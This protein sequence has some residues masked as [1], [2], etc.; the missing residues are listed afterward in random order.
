[1]RQSAQAWPDRIALQDLTGSI[2]V[3][4]AELWGAVESGASVLRQSGLEPRDRVLLAADAGPGWM[5]S[6][7]S[8]SHAG[9]VAVPIPPTTPEP[10]VRLVLK[11]ADVRACV[12]DRGSA[13]QATCFTP[14]DLADPTAVPLPRVASDPSTTAVLVFTSGSTSRPRAVALSH[15]ALRANLRSVQA[16]RQAQPGEALLSTLPPSH[17]YE[18]VAGQLAPLASG[19]RVVYAGVPLPN[20]V[21]DAIRTQAITRMLLVPALFEALVRDVVDGLIN[22]GVV[23]ESCRHLSPRD[24]AARAR[25]LAPDA[26]ARLRA[27]IRER[28]GT[29]LRNVTIGG[30]ATDPA[31]ADVLST[32]GIDLDVGYGL[33]EAGPVVAIGRASQCPAGSVGRPLPGVDVRIGA[34]EEVLV[35]SEAVMQGYAGDASATAAAFAGTWLRTGDRGRVDTNGFL[36]I[37]GRIKEAM[38]T[39]AG[40]T[41]YPDEIEPY[42]SSPLFAE[43]AVVPAAGA[44]GNDQPTL[45][46]VPSGAAIDERTIR[47]SVAALRAAAPARLRVSGF[48]C[49]RLPLPRTA[50][51]KIRRRA[52][53]DEL[54][55]H[56]VTS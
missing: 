26:V 17:A 44:D 8:I 38:V 29:S 46:I 18:L 7:L 6:F 27:A 22:L 43:L 34:D 49:W 10:L 11:F 47:Q 28:I 20:R 31:W 56:E 14:A 52:L 5:T 45:V 25:R 48:V 53:A 23:D 3:P 15:A 35:R 40:E 30:A 54:R 32:V 1:V 19:A 13:L 50:V 51:G 42:Y 33:T 21:I 16:V 24:L 39:S 37:T 4:Y 12:I 36:F 2:R 9:L 41:I 55:S